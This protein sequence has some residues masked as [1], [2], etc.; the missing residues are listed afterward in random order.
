MET[1]PKFASFVY[2]SYVD[3]S[4]LHHEEILRKNASQGD[5]Q[6]FKALFDRYRTPLF[7]FISN[8]VKSQEV[9]EELVMDVFLKLWLA[10]D[11]LPEIENLDGFLFRIAYNKSI[12]F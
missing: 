5:E 6:A 2:F 3:S 8:I 7:E 4:E 12:D 9:A 1:L 10:M 11:M